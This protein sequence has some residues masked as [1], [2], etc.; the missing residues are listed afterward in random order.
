M[1]DKPAA[2]LFVH[3]AQEQINTLMSSFVRMLNVLL[4]KFTSADIDF[5]IWHGFFTVENGVAN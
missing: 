5:P 4:A 1:G 3:S 2:L